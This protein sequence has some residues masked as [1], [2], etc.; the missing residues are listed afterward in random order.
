M[1]L[2]R[3]ASPR[4]SSFRGLA[5]ALSVAV[6]TACGGGSS[7]T[8]PPPPPSNLAPVATAQEVSVAE[9][10]S[11]PI[12]LGGTDPEGD[13]LT[14]EVRTAPAHGTLTG[15]P[16][17]LTYTPGA[18]WSGDDHFTVVASDGAHTSAEATIVVHVLHVNHRPV[19]NG[20]AAGGDE[21]TA[22]AVTLTGA[23]V[24]GDLLTF[25]ISTQPAHGAVVLTGD[26]ATYTP[27]A[28]W[29][30]VDAFRFVASD[31][32]LDSVEAVVTVTVAA[33]NDPPWATTLAASVAVVEDTPQTFS[34]AANAGDVE[35]SAL[36]YAVHTQAAHGYVSC[37]AATGSCTYTPTTNYS[38][39]DGFQFRVYDG[40][41][42]STPAGVTFAISAVNDPPFASGA[43][44][45]VA[46]DGSVAVTL[47]ATDPEGDALTWVVGAPSHGTLTGTAPSLTY[48]PAANYHGSDGFTFTA[49]D[50]TL[51]SNVATV[52]I[53][54]TSVND[55]PVASAGSA[56][57]VNA[58]E[59]ARLDGTGSSD[60]DGNALTYAWTQTAGPAVTLDDPTTPTPSFLATTAGTLTFQLVV[61]DG[62]LSSAPATVSVDVLAYA[63]ASAVTLT[64]NPFLIGGYEGYTGVTSHAIAG[65]RLYLSRGSSVQ[66]VDVTDPKAPALLGAYS[67][68]VDLCD[69]IAASGTTLYVYVNGS[70]RVVD[71]S[72]PASPVLRG[73]VA[74][75][76]TP[77]EIAV[78]GSY[79]YVA[80]GIALH[81]VDVSTPTH[82]FV[83]GSVTLGCGSVTVSGDYAYVG[84]SSG[85]AIVDV[86]NPTAPAV[87]TTV[88]SGTPAGPAVVSGNRAYVNV[89]GAV[90]GVWVLD[91]RVP[92]APTQLGKYSTSGSAGALALTGSEVVVANGGQGLLRIDFSNILYPQL[93]AKLPTLQSAY[94]VQVANGH[95]FV[96]EGAS[97]RVEVFDLAQPWAMPW[98][99]SFAFGGRDDG[100]QVNGIEARAGRLYVAQDGGLLVF[101]LTNPATPTLMGSR[102]ATGGFGYDVGVSGPTAF[103]ADF[104]ALAAVNAS[105]PS[106]MSLA[107]RLTIGGTVTRVRLSGARAYVAAGLSGFH[108]VNVASPAAMVRLGG[109][110]TV[111][112]TTDVAVTGTRGLVAD[113]STLIV[114]DV[115][116]PA[117]PLALGGLSLGAVG[118]AATPSHAFVAAGYDGLKVVSLAVPASPAV[119]AT[120]AT[121]RD[122]AGVDLVGGEAVVTYSNDLSGF[123]AVDVASPATP[124]LTGHV[125]VAGSPVSRPGWSGRFLYAGDTTYDAAA[126]LHSHFL[127]TYEWKPRFVTRYAQAAA[128]GADL[129]YTVSWVESVTPHDRRVRCW[130]TGGS[131]T[132]DAIDQA[133]NTATVRWT[134]PAAAGDHELRIAVGTQAHFI[135]DVDRVSFQ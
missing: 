126:G 45:T 102:F 75:T 61:S 89:G 22:V 8:T 96:L 83:A 34:L 100:G 57:T 73:S 101:G 91:V 112:T 134:P 109:V 38:G 58:G 6:L 111:G 19:A 56:Q 10:G 94:G 42:H 81:V 99:A 103:V 121:P 37:V 28:D 44:A 32:L 17:A 79:A 50:G 16:P 67:C 118:V 39:P 77:A 46:E 76:G 115:S 93:T 85:L 43:S 4:R 11:L 78:S 7:A 82:P 97:Q 31:G 87:A 62:A 80:T 49:S 135:S 52:S 117:S 69:R 133:A 86:W 14:F 95:A 47:S 98:V 70:L 127:R 125:A 55:A 90:G 66:I 25:A 35:A 108:I 20:S 131:C 116:N 60:V 106:A 74:V 54:V 124:S 3:A 59:T 13:A 110:D 68:G 65:S 40:A 64:K 36:Q 84:T 130:V 27:A 107:S 30:G 1:L 71:A 15:T 63:G 114:Y 29:S 92:S 9:D 23:D 26:V 119:V 128:G 104:T 122:A 48:H 41:L 129:V 105:N 123:L 88:L 18:G 53:T 24:D 132:V 72:T 33:V 2:D 12:T 51:T 21:D 113:S 120:L 5:C